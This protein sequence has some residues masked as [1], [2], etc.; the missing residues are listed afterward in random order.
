MKSTRVKEHELLAKGAEAHQLETNAVKLFDEEQSGK[1]VIL[2]RFQFQLLPGIKEVNK[3][4]LLKE[5]V[6]RLEVFLWKDELE[7]VLPPKL[8]MEKNGAFSIFVT[9][10]PKKGSL[11]SYKD[12]VQT[13]QNALNPQVHK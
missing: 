1:P 13:V 11:L 4:L 7:M 12:K 2:R 6:K 9:C 10:E 3:K 8:V 5:H